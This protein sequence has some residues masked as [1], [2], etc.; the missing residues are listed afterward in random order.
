MKFIS[1]LTIAACAALA[2]GVFASCGGNKQTEKSAQSADSVAH[3][4]GPKLGEAASGPMLDKSSDST[5]Q[6]MIREVVPTFKQYTFTDSVSGHTMDYNLYEPAGTHSKPLPLVLFIA[7]AS[8]PGRDVTAPLTQGYGGIIWATKEAQT[9][10][11]CYVLVPQFKGVAVDDSYRHTDEV[12]IAMRLLQS[13]VKAKNIDP[14][15]LYSTGQSMGGMISMY[16]DVAYPDVF[17]ASIFIDSHWATDTFDKLVKHKFIY[18]IAGDSGKAYKCL[19]PMEDA[20]RREGVAYCYAEWS[21][22]VP[23]ERQDSLAQVML[24]KGDPVNLF[25]FEPKTVLPADGRGSEHMLSFDC[26]YRIST[27]REW[28]FRQ[29]K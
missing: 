16:Y 23:V 1:T 25:Q 9:K 24:D 28:L 4:G 6:A 26:A 17:A 11:P 14:D 5:L 2:I 21:V 27:T 20:C 3:R 15:R 18:F 12:D 19:E 13:V 22:K 10:N 29:S 7:D 8:T